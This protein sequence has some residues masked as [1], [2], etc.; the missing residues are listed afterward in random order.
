MLVNVKSNCLCAVPIQARKGSDEKPAP[1]ELP[2]K[3]S[4]DSAATSKSSLSKTN[5]RGGALEDVISPSPKKNQAPVKT[6]SKLAMM[7]KRDE[8]R[9]EGQKSKTPLSPA[10]IKISPKKEPV[11][12]ISDM[13][14]TPKTGTT[15]TA[16]K[17]SPK[18]PEVSR[19]DAS[20]VCY[21]VDWQCHVQLY[22]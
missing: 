5:Q 22:Q 17:I 13:K 3:S 4:T 14:F 15:P 11:T 8:E 2:K 12:S 16:V 10:K 20:S 19:L 6:S 1:A 21:N 18:K 9:N 7:K